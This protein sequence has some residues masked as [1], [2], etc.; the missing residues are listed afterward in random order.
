VDSFIVG[1]V[2]RRT[3]LLI[4]VLV[5]SKLRHLH[6]EGS[7]IVALLVILAIIP[8]LGIPWVHSQSP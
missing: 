3:F 4:F 6:A 2:A 8:L 7:E 5:M 1:V